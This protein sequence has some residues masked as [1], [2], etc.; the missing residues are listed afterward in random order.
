[1]TQRTGEI[2]V[3]MALGARRAQ[4]VW[5]VLSSGLRLVGLGLALGVPAALLGARLI[6]GM[7]Y[8]LSATDAATIAA[9]TVVLA[10]TG[11]AAAFVPA[12][13]ASRVEPTVA[14]RCE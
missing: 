13:R 5:M 1:V 6:S 12:L 11:A 2:G 14:L 7:L 9:A 3:R 10:A 8:G 4:V